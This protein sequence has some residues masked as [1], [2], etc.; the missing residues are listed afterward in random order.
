MFTVVI[1][2]V[3]GLYLRL[4]ESVLISVFPDVAETNV[5]KKSK[6]VAAVSVTS[7]ND[8]ESALPVN[9]PVTLPVI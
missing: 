6:L 5:G 7:T 9:A 8:A 2:L 4:V 1:V 3:D